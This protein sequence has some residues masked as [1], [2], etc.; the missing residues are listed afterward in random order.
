[1]LDVV[2]SI[3]FGVTLLTILFVYSSIGSAGLWL[4]TSADVLSMENWQQYHVRQWRGLEMT[5][6][7]WFHW[8]PFDV[9]IGLICAAIITATLRRIPFKPVNFGVWMIHTGLI[10]LAIGSFYYFGTKVEGDAPVVRRAV[11]INVPGAEQTMLVALPG[12][13]T[14]IRTEDDN[15]TFDVFAIDP[16]WEILSGE[17]R[18]TRAYKVS[19]RVQNKS[20]TFIREL[21]AGYPQYTEDL[22]FDP[23]AHQPMQRAKKV[24]NTALVDTSLDL[25]LQPYPQTHFHLMNSRALY[26]REAGSSTWS[27]RPISGLPRYNDYVQST[28]DIWI[29]AGSATLRPDPIDLALSA[30]DVADPLAGTEI[31]VNGYLRYAIEQPRNMPGGDTLDPI[32]S[33]LVQGGDDV[34]EQQLRAF[35]PGANTAA[36]G[37]VRF[38]WANTPAAREAL[39]NAEPP[40]LSITVPATGAVGTIEISAVS[41]VT[42]DLPYTPIEGTN[43]AYRVH[44]HEDAL[45]LSAD[46]TVAVAIVEL[47]SPERTFVRWVFE[48]PGRNLDFDTADDGSMSGEP[49]EKDTSVEFAYRPGATDATLVAG[50]GDDQLSLVQSGVDGVRVTPLARGGSFLVAGGTSVTVQRY[51][52]RTIEVIKPTVVPPAQRNR[53][54]DLTGRFTMIRVSIPGL[55]EHWLQQQQYVF[56][57]PDEVLFR[58]PQNPL[59]LRRDNAPDLEVVFARAR[60][61]LP[62][63]VMLDDFKVLEHVGGFVG[64]TTSIRDWVSEVRFR[65]DEGWSDAASVQVN[66]PKANEGFWFFQAQWDPPEPQ[67][68][69]A[70]LNYTVLGVGNRNGV[71]IQLAGC[72]LSVVGMLYAFYVKPIIRRRQRQSVYAAAARGAAQSEAGGQSTAEARAVAEPGEVTS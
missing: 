46:E 62:A 13:S 9:L 72:C 65:E 1:V 38:A 21:L 69:Y 64:S 5:E 55:G 47:R 19:V 7:E 2:G 70:G 28:E 31:R 10:I 32:V 15:W 24:L 37:R 26:L 27:Q 60:E 59:V 22:L 11:S 49:A 44:R 57:R 39:E 66:A 54:A 45:P 3:W 12:S 8:W 67:R 53:N 58:Y 63:P 30:S 20:G 16:N 6:F 14:T 4:P 48:E 52:A 36:G 34:V 25:G 18:G 29:G 40:R 41:H 51:A 43:L 68:R 17:D 23:G 35:D 50:P 33:L 61:E 56:D 71:N 42:P